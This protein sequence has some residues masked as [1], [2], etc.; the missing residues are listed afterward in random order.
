MENKQRHSLS[1]NAFVSSSTQFINNNNNQDTDIQFDD[2]FR[3]YEKHSL[4]YFDQE[5]EDREKYENQLL[6]GEY[7]A[8]Y[9]DAEQ[10]PLF[11]F[12][13]PSF[14][15]EDDLFADPFNFELDYQLAPKACSDEDGL[16]LKLMSLDSP[17]CKSAD[18][19]TIDKKNRE[20]NNKPLNKKQSKALLPVQNSSDK[21]EEKKSSNS[22]SPLSVDPIKLQKLL[23][24]L[25]KTKGVDKTQID[26]DIVARTIEFGQQKVADSLHIPY[27]RYKSILNKVGIKTCAGRKVKNLNF[28][29]LLAEWSLKVKDQS[30]LLTR[31]MIKDK[32]EELIKELIAEGDLSLRK[33]RLSK[34]WLDKFVK[35]HVEIKDYLTSQKGKKGH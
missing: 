27:R 8:K 33:I 34:G 13:F 15:V 32:A 28:E 5:F 23:K 14:K 21:V 17:R 31:K 25:N 24:C 12:G 16:T 22:S 1:N 35:R 29:N 20:M 26:E 3:F 6:T 18:L 9:E 10:R 30:N 2:S 19:F 11:N 7:R 4:N